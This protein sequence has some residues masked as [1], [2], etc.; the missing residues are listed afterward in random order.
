MAYERLNGRSP[1]SP[2]SEDPARPGYSDLG[3]MAARSSVLAGAASTWAAG[4]PWEDAPIHLEDTLSP[5]LAQTG[6]APGCMWTVPTIPRPAPWAVEVF[7]YPG[8]GGVIYPDQI[9]YEWPFVP[10]DFV[11][12]PMGTRTGPHL[13][14]M[15]FG[16]IL[17]LD[18]DETV[19]PTRIVSASLTGPAGAVEVRTVDQSTTGPRGNLGRYLEGGMLIPVAPL[20]PGS[21]YRARA[22]LLYR[23]VDPLDVSWTFRTAGDDAAGPRGRPRVRI[24]GLV[25]TPGSIRATLLGAEAVGRRAVIST[26]A[27]GRECAAGGERDGARGCRVGLVG[28]PAVRRITLRARQTI[29]LSRT[30]FGHR[31]EVAVRAFSAGGGRYG[32]VRL[33]SVLR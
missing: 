5:K 19:G 25:R 29:T 32:R 21:S 17:D 3:L 23:G 7:T 8:P 26:Q 28:R 12:L 16:G 11:G 24:G 33:V 2:H 10:G 6:W 9:A 15:P 14:V 20:S 13:L 4:N 27:R 1:T 31:L 22:T 18:P 30:R